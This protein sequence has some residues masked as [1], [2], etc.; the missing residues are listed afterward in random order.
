MGSSPIGS[1]NERQW[2]RW[3][4]HGTSNAVTRR[5]NSCLAL[6]MINAVL[7]QR[8]ERIDPNDE[9]AGWSPADGSIVFAREAQRI[10]RRRPKPKGCGFEPHHALH[11]SVARAGLVQRKNA[12]LT[13]KLCGFDSCTRHQFERLHP[14]I[15]QLAERVID[16]RE[17]VGST[18]TPWTNLERASPSGKA[19]GFH[20]GIAWVRIPPPAP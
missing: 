3:M 14:G 15:A 2:P 9:D 1:T 4:R 8:R 12:C 11:L 18:P 7:A 5:F 6:Q 13:S 20:P 16:N 17:A 10:E 19:P